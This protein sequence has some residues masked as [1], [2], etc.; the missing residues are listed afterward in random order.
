M[1]EPQDALPAGATDDG[2]ALSDAVTEELL[3]DGR[4][5]SHAESRLA[6]TVARLIQ[7]LWFGSAAFLLIAASAAFRAAS[8]PTEAADVVGALLTRWHYISLFGP[9]VLMLMEWRRSRPAILLTLFLAIVL[10]SGGAI[11]DTRI[12]ALRIESAFPMTERSH[13][14][15]IRRR[16]GM[17]HGLS[18]AM[19]LL[20]LLLAGATIAMDHDRDGR[21]DFPP[22]S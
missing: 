5:E 10:A 1:T 11:L 17:M 6:R 22:S 21:P 7:A 14:D 2:D 15:P 16:F 4:L 8:S 13:D 20:E 19:L 9:L 12:R 3:L 18:S